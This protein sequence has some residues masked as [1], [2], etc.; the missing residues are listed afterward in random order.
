MTGTS[1]AAGAAHNATVSTVSND[2]VGKVVR[3]CLGAMSGSLT[4]GLADA[5]TVSPSQVLDL[6]GVD[7]GPGSVHAEQ[8]SKE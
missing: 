4:A 3:L 1:S 5:D 2:R 6:L 7:Y 8:F